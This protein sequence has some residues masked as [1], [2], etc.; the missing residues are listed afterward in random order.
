MKKIVSEWAGP[1]EIVLDEEN[2]FVQFV[3]WRMENGRRRPG[4]GFTLRL[5]HLALN[6]DAIFLLG[7]AI[8]LAKELT[9]HAPGGKCIFKTQGGTNA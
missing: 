6:Q 1:V 7:R 5:E 9:H 8:K 4:P 2:L 3:P